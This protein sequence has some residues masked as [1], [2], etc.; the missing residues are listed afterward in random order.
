QQAFS[1]GN[2]RTSFAVGQGCGRRGDANLDLNS[3]AGLRGPFDP[4]RGPVERAN[5]D[6]T[7]VRLGRQ[8]PKEM[9]DTIDDCKR[10]E[11]RLVLFDNVHAYDVVH[12]AMTEDAPYNCAPGK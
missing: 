7:R 5:A 6:R 9:P 4:T 12:G 11:R 3:R 2:L 10:R 1:A 8:Q